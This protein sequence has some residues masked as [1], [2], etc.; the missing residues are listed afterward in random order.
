MDSRFAIGIM[1]DAEWE[2]INTHY[3]S[4]AKGYKSFM[5]LLMIIGIGLVTFYCIF[6]YNS[7]VHYLPDHNCVAHLIFLA[8]V[9]FI[10]LV[11]VLGF[12]LVLYPLYRDLSGKE[13]ICETAKILKKYTDINQQER[14]FD[15]YHYGKLT[16]NIDFFKKFDVGDEINIE[17]S[18][19]AKEF[20]NY[21]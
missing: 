20:F 11:G 16:V 17:Y 19:H 15:L 7:D 3:S 1:S 12:L 5:N 4:L 2:Q 8:M 14:F 6:H 9:V 10:V 21:F 13:K 18:R